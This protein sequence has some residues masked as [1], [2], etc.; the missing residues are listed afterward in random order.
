MPAAGASTVQKRI[1]ASFVMVGLASAGLGA[2]VFALFSD[3]AASSGN[4]FT[5]GVL[6]LE[7][8]GPGN[9]ES[10]LGG[11]AMLPGRTFNGTLAI[12]NDGDVGGSDVDLDIAVDIETSGGVDGA[13]NIAEV[14]RIDVL[15]YGGAP[16][17]VPDRNGNGHVD[18]DDWDAD[19]GAT[20]DLPDPGA[21]SDLYLEVTFD[22]LAGNL[23]MGDSAN[24]TF[25]FLLS[26]IEGEDL[27]QGPTGFG[28][29]YVYS[30]TIG[31]DIV[32]IFEDA[33]AAPVGVDEFPADLSSYDV[34][35]LESYA[36]ASPDRLQLLLD[37]VE[38]GGSVLLTG[39]TPY[40]MCGS[41]GSVSC[42]GWFGSASYT[43]RDGASALV[44]IDNVFGTDLDAG[45]NILG[46][47]G[48][49][50]SAALTGWTSPAVEVAEWSGGDDA[51]ALT[52]DVAG[53]RVAWAAAFTDE[54]GS[55][56]YDVAHPF[57]VGLLSWLAEGQ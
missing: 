42:L 31:A 54:G 32:D 17:A 12:R 10:F 4:I 3:T 52:A 14:L 1:L 51:F 24:V 53:G 47:T 15:T 34:I 25:Q 11:S 29:L 50:G 19:N 57:F 9:L 7:I 55:T 45:D 8:D 39:G 36:Q 37:F 6:D 16:I 46:P 38:D 40:I 41:V 56:H 49:C 20:R 23:Y 30:T 26:Q 48:C 2:G 33:G 43:N 21:G 35:V 44:T 5:A 22:L 28:L 27:A 13:G 18:L